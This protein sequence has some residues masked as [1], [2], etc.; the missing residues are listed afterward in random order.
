VRKALAVAFVLAAAAGAAAQEGRPGGRAEGRPD[1]GSRRPPRE[2][3]FRMVDA[4]VAEHL[5]ES[6]AL[7]DEQL[8]RLMPLVRKLNADRRRLAE[9][10]MHALFQMRRMFKDGTATDARIAELLQQVKSAEVEEPT[11]IRAGHDA[12]DAQLT[13]LQQA[14]F[15]VLEAEV[16]HRVRQVMARVRGQRAGRPGAPPDEPRAPNDPR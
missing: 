9:R 10:R 6:L 1:E 11:A 4:Y 3:I 14:Q 13:P 12:I 15:R 5:Q 16:E 7:S 8:N 2:E